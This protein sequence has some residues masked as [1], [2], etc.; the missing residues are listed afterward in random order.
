MN[1]NELIEAIASAMQGIGE[2]ITREIIQTLDGRMNDRHAELLASLLTIQENMPTSR[3]V[4]EMIRDNRDFKREINATIN[5]RL[6]KQD[7]KIDRIESDLARH[8]R[9]HVA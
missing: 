5:A 2:N 3:D 7:E 4:N 9:G 6:G 8:I 1:D